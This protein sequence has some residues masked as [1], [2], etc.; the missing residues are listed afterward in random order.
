MLTSHV[1]RRQ[2]EED[3]MLFTHLWQ[4]Y[5]TQWSDDLGI[6]LNYFSKA[7][8]R[9]RLTSLI[10]FFFS[11]CKL[12]DETADTR[13]SAASSSSPG[14]DRPGCFNR[15]NPS[16]H[17]LLPRYEVVLDASL[18][19]WT[20]WRLRGHAGVRVI[21][22][23]NHLWPFPRPPYMRCV[24]QLDF[25]PLVKHN[26]THLVDA[27]ISLRSDRHVTPWIRFD[28]HGAPTTNS[29]APL[30][31]RSCDILY[32]IWSPHICSPD[33]K[34][35]S[36]IYCRH[37]QAWWRI[38]LNTICSGCKCRDLET[39]SID[40]WK[41][42]LWAAPKSKQRIHVIGIGVGIGRSHSWMIGIGSIKSCSEHL[43]FPSP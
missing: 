19:Y 27:W 21:D 8:Q 36:T 9:R 5:S 38:R 33:I 25:N 13:F 31:P 24:K 6:L 3:A 37:F 42:H 10:F 2:G 29:P 26:P 1:S 40:S 32:R 23:Q 43:K 18:L 41:N 11:C 16:C 15:C 22:G 30:T 20:G 34:M 12:I 7:S 17:N 39:L 4:P 14:E 28:A 35:T